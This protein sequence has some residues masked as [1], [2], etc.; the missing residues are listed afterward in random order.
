MLAYLVSIVICVALKIKKSRRSYKICKK[1][2]AYCLGYAVLSSIGNLFL[3]LALKELPA[4]VQYP[5]VTGGV[6]ALSTMISA[7]KKEKVSI[8]NFIAAVLAF[9][10]SILMAF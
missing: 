1:A 9:S 4:S 3:L 5:I 8:K 2:A 7:I 10:A 6:I